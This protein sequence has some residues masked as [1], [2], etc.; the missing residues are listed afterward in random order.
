MG[1]A[2]RWFAIPLWRRVVGGL[3]IGVLLGLFWPAAA[4]G[5]AFIGELLESL[6]EPTIDCIL[7]FVNIKFAI[8]RH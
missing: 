1:P 5:I 7:P 6:L 3:V 8:F 2:R 4:P